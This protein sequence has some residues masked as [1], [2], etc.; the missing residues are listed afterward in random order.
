M[1]NEEIK[2]IEEEYPLFKEFIEFCKQHDCEVVIVPKEEALT[3]DELFG[4]RIVNKEEKK[5]KNFK[6]LLT[7]W[8]YVETKDGNVGIVNAKLDGISFKSRAFAETTSYDNEL[9]DTD[10]SDMTVMKIYEPQNIRQCDFDSYINGKLIFDRNR[11][12]PDKPKFNKEEI[13]KLKAIKT[14]LGKQFIYVARDKNNDLYTY[15]VNPILATNN[16]WCANLYTDYESRQIAELN[17][18][19]ITFENSPVNIEEAIKEYEKW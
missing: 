10:S 2:F 7:D 3:Y 5:M 6:E 14:V 4:K 13:E 1:T 16:K 12:C 17:Y 19:F 18:D 9:K 15:S 8:V 11:D